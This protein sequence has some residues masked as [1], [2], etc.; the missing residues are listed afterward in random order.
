M[1]FKPRKSASILRV[2]VALVAI[3]AL[4]VLLARALWRRTVSVW[5]L[6]G[7]LW[8]LLSVPLLFWL[9]EQLHGL[10]GLAYRLDRNKLEIHWRPGRRFV[11]LAEIERIV[12]LHS[13]GLP[14]FTRYVLL[15]TL[16]WLGYLV[17]RGRIAGVGPAWFCVTQPWREQWA[18]VTPSLMYVI[19]PADP[20]ALL[21]ALEERRALGPTYVMQLRQQRSAFARWSLRHDAIGAFALVT[22]VLMALLLAYVA[23][24]QPIFVFMTLGEIVRS[25]VFRLTLLG[26]LLT[27]VDV[28][29]AIILHQ[30]HRAPA[31]L[32]AVG[33]FFLQLALWVAVS[34]RMSL[35]ALSSISFRFLLGLA[36]SA[37][38]GLVAYRKRA[39]S[40]S[41][42]VGALVIGVLVFGFGGWE[43]G[44]VL[45]AFF[46]SSSLLSLYR[47]QAKEKIAEKFA[48]GSQRDLGQALANGG[49]GALLA[50]GSYFWPHAAWLPAFVG[51]MATVTADTW[52]TELGVLNPHLPRFITTGQEVPVG[53]SGGVSPLGLGATAVGALFVGVLMWLLRLIAE[54]VRQHGWSGEF[55]SQGT[56]LLPVA[57]VGGIVGSLADSLLGATVQGIYYCDRCGKETER[58]VHRCGAATRH[59]RGYTWLNNDLVNLLSSAAGGAVAV[60]VARLLW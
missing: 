33:A 48:K 26:T 43:W 27:L 46:I 59:L 16:P 34:R 11:P 3:V 18:V 19:S 55:A 57:L 24:N 7:G 23:S 22:L 8:L 39:L 45:I 10:V 53:T 37:A 31:Y 1:E 54:V 14:P 21:A 60:L 6:V 5:T 35:G 49:L 9:G 30:R 50:V 47:Q 28:L 29:L 58:T 36:L 13:L 32:F 4:D 52:A 41:G 38:I 51:V 2:A 42:I 12:P 25:R 40:R 15:N 20:Q 44:L 56:W 17:G